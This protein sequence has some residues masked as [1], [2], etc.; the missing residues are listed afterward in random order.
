[1]FRY[2]VTPVGYFPVGQC[3]DYFAWRILLSKIKALYG[4]YIYLK[5]ELFL[6]YARIGRF[7]VLTTA[8]KLII[9]HRT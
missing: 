4:E 2:E 9:H 7:G 1:M 3:L 6:S 8:S 5:K